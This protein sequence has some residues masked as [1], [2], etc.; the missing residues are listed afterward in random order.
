[1]PLD[2]LGVLFLSVGRFG[3]HF[4]CPAGQIKGRLIQCTWG[5]SPRL[6]LPP[7]LSW[8]GDNFERTLAFCL[9]KLGVNNSINVIRELRK[10]NEESS[11]KQSPKLDTNVNSP[12]SQWQR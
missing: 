6:P 11:T 4:D 2:F 10:I 9:C 8:Y 7:S 3:G 12:E 1:M 5:T